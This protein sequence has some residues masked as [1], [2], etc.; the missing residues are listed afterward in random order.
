M[1]VCIVFDYVLPETCRHRPRRVNGVVAERSGGA[2]GTAKEP[3][4]DKRQ[5][6]GKAPLWRG[7]SIR[8]TDQNT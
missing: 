1:C 8:E 5:V 2:G 4:E 3:G 7:E 6:T